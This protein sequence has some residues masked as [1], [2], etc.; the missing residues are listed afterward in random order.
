MGLFKEQAFLKLWRDEYLVPDHGLDLNSAS[1]T[2]TCI[3]SPR[4]S[5]SC[6]DSA[7]VG[8]GWGLRVCICNKFPGD[9]MGRWPEGWRP[10][11]SLTAGWWRAF[12]PL[13]SPPL[14]LSSLFF[15]SQQEIRKSF[16]KRGD[17]RSLPECLIV[18]KRSRSVVTR[19]WTF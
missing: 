17:S 6:E 8:L 9:A 12:V 19:K 13:K 4:G 14:R 3:W 7:S 5:C 2:S 10:K 1:R 11:C 16:E 18:W 15:L